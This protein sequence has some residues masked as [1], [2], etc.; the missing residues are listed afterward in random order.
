MPDFA[1]YVSDAR[2]WAVRSE[3][4]ADILAREN[5]VLLLARLDDEPVGYC[6]AYPQSTA[7]RAWA[8]DTWQVEGPIVEIESLGVAPE[9]RGHGIG[10]TL[11]RQTL[12]SFATVPETRFVIG[13]VAGNRSAIKLYQKF[14]FRPTWTYLTTFGGS[15]P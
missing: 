6:L 4:Y 13:A 5:S 14:G 15:T 9:H 1:P 8:D 7:E 12:E 10:T 3:L 2:T 11:L